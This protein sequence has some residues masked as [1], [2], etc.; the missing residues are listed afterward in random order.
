MKTKNRLPDNIGY[1]IQIMG[2]ACNVTSDRYVLLR[3]RLLLRLMRIKSNSKSSNLSRVC[4]LE[5]LQMKARLTLETRLT[6]EL[7]SCRFT[8]D[9][10][11]LPVRP[12]LRLGI[13]LHFVASVTQ[14]LSFFFFLPYQLA[15]QQIAP[16]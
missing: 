1:I 14:P 2:T 16:R 4:P 6:I 11:F 5:C 9:Q 12:R 10:N 3:C 7:T 15:Y 13:G 8:L